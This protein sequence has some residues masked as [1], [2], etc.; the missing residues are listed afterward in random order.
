SGAFSVPWFRSRSV[1]ENVTD[2]HSWEAGALA[3][4][5]VVGFLLTA[6]VL[7]LPL[8]ALRS[9]RHGPGP[10]PLAA[11]ALGGCGVYFVL[12]SSLDWLFLIPA[13]AIPGF[14]VLGALATGGTVGNL[15][16]PG[17]KERLLVA[18]AALVAAVAAFP[19]Y[20]ATRE[21]NRAEAQAAATATALDDLRIAT[22]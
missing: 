21:T 13:V 1:D 9:A 11:V 10:W 2:A 5:G 18:A 14:L 8:I 22:N 6:A 4:T 3:E 15:V 20:L 16:L 19:A 12:H 17:R 7:L